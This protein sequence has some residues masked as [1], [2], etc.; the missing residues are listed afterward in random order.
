MARPHVMTPARKA[1]L[2]KAQ[3]ASA[4]K[5]KSK[6]KSRGSRRSSYLKKTAISAGATLAVSAG[7]IYFQSRK[8]KVQYTKTPVVSTR[9]GKGRTSGP[10]RSNHPYTNATRQ[11]F[12]RR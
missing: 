3:R 12:R 11:R 4:R 8:R 5:R 10:P 2:R 1:A 6:G 9:H 7:V